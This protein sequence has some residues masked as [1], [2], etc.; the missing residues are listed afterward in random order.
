MSEQRHVVI[1]AAGKG[2]RMRSKKQKVFHK[3]AGRTLLEHTLEA[4]QNCEAASITVVLSP[5]QKETEDFLNQ[6]YPAVQVAFQ[7]EQKGTGDAVL[8]AGQYLEGLSGTVLILF[9]DTPLIKSET[10]RRLSEHREKT[11]SAVTVLALEAPKHPDYGRLIKDDQGVARIV[12]MKDTTAAEKE[13]SLCNSGLMACRAESLLSLLNKLKP[14][15]QAEEY[16]LTDI[17][18]LARQN[19]DS[20]TFLIVDDGGE[21]MGINTRKDLA[22]A[23]SIMQKRL[24]GQAMEAGVTFLDP[25]TVYL[26]YDTSFG[27]DVMVH[28]HVFFGPKVEI[29]E[30]VTIYSFSHLEGACVKEGAQVGPYARLRPGT[31][32]EEDSRVGNFVELKKAT[33][34]RGSKANHLSYLGDTSIGE[35]CNIGAGTITCNYNGYQKKKT[36]LEDEVFVGSNS[37]LIAP[38]TI[39]KG[40]YVAAG[41]TVTK[42][43]KADALA[44]S[45]TLQTE[46]EGGAEKLRQRFRRL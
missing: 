12:E 46:R 17:V 40:A 24:R 39:H 32:L 38:V 45:R 44:L 10:L 42:D 37:T 1:L 9:A 14:K 43:V 30:D 26:S 33:L 23:E 31:V 29:K 25:S 16:Y 6:A 8:A 7:N 19:E 36:I 3:L 15:N 18:S 2:T 4:A 27:Q 22:D 21:V 11:K 34:G 5:D 35:K 13:I 28:P 20:V 41:T